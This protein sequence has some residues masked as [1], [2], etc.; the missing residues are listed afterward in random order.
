MSSP[1]VSASALT[2]CG[3]ARVLKRQKPRS[4]NMITAAD[5]GTLFHKLVEGWATTGVVPVCD[6]LE[7]QGWLDL[8]AMS[9][10]PPKTALFELA[11][12]LGPNGEYVDV[13][14]PLPHVYTPKAGL[15]VPLL[16]AGRA[17][18]VWLIDGIVYVL[19]WKT[20]V[21]AVEQAA[22]NLQFWALGLAAAAKVRAVGIR[23]GVCYVRDGV[24]EWSDLVEVGSLAHQ[25]RW[26]DVRAAATVGEAP[27][28]GVNCIGCWERKSCSHA[29]VPDAA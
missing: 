15:G 17:D 7:M 10:E 14:E 12:G 25:E 4:A 3:W 13:E 16:T 20:G 28:P 21:W 2:R 26:E 24:F 9:W 27:R 23:V 5:R 11:L 18:V 1:L 6:D 8:L 22:T 29:E 19:D